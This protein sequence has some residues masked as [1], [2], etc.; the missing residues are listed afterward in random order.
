MQVYIGEQT[1]FE[2]FDEYLE[3]CNEAVCARLGLRPRTPI[4][5]PILNKIAEHLWQNRSRDI[6]VE[7]LVKFT[8]NQLLSDLNWPLSKAC[9]IEAEGLLVCR[10]R[11]KGKDAMS[12]TYD[13]LGGYL[14][15]KHLVEQAAD[16]VQAFLNSE[17]VVALLT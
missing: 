4:V 16:D 14:I 13:L 6:L 15:A 12:F 9:A 2:V 11:W 7:E 3:Q 8:D 5:Q 1:L 17:E 10:N